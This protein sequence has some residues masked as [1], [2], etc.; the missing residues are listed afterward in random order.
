MEKKYSSSDDEREESMQVSCWGR[1]M[2]T[3]SRSTNQRKLKNGSSS[4]NFPFSKKKSKKQSNAF[5]YSPLSYAQN[6]DDGLEWEADDQDSLF[7]GF[8]SR[9]AAPFSSQSTKT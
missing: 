7:R 3:F 2:L 4:S 9:Y 1:F 8:S 5:R 6:F